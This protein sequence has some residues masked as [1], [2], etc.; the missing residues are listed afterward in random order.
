MIENVLATEE[1]SEF[2]LNAESFVYNKEPSMII[3][4]DSFNI[5]CDDFLNFV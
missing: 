4:S 3:D 2:N 5:D 1:E